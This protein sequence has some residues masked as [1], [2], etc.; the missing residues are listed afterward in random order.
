MARPDARA[1][2]GIQSAAVWLALAD[3]N[4]PAPPPP[5]S[6]PSS[7]DSYKFLSLSS[8]GRLHA[9]FPSA[10]AGC[11]G[12]LRP[13]LGEHE[14][15]KGAVVGGVRGVGGDVRLRCAGKTKAED[16]FLRPEGAMGCS[17]G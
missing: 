8:R 17:H 11:G 2:E 4:A 15:G 10:D 7:R 1:T 5:A 13:A 3:P 9:D 6:C 12:V 16:S 14:R